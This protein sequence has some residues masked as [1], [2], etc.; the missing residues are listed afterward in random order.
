MFYSPPTRQYQSSDLWGLVGF[1]PSFSVERREVK[2]G[3]NCPVMAWGM[4]RLGFCLLIMYSWVWKSNTEFQI[5]F[6]P[7]C[8]LKNCDITSLVSWFKVLFAGNVLGKSSDLKK[9]L[10]KDFL[11]MD[12]DHR[13]SWVGRDTLGS[14]S[15]TPRY[16]SSYS[17]IFL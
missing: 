10:R 3:E 14:L 9:Y 8:N 12:W 5:F 11:G 17:Y 6:P 4:N 16:H 15:I 2:I 1:F 13:M 7:V